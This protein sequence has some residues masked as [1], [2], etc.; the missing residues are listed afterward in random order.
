MKKT[1][2]VLLA[3]AVLAAGISSM[4]MAAGDV[5]QKSVLSGSAVSVVAPGTHVK[6]GDVLVTVESLVGP[7]PAA[8]ATS[9]GVVKQ[10]MVAKGSKVE[11]E[12]VV[13]IIA[14]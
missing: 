9:D 5:P 7:V 13:A 4:A 6:Q 2:K 11:P 12:Q 1:Y 8:R 10:V 3:A 14:E